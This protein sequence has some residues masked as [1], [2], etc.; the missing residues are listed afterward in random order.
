MSVF[1][2]E[3]F[4]SLGLTDRHG[5]AVST[6]PLRPC[7]SRKGY[8]SQWRARTKCEYG[9]RGR[10]LVADVRGLQAD[11]S[12]LGFAKEGPNPLVSRE[13]MLLCVS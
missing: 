6:R 13:I 7:Q 2:G 8:S 10:E 5:I 12:L 9:I 4:P 1:A 11:V 3:L